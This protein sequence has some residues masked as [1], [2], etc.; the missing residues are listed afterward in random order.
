MLNKLKRKNL[1][2]IVLNDLTEAGA[3]FAKDTNI[4]TI[5]HSDGRIEKLPKMLKRDLADEILNRVLL[6][7]QNRM[8]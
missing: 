3:G 2:F 7:L 4:V 8:S 6:Y 5:L 1:D